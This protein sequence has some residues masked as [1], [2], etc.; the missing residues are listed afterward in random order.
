MLQVKLSCTKVVGL[1]VVSKPSWKRC[2]LRRDLKDCVNIV[3]ISS[4]KGNGDSDLP[5]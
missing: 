2:V 5:E 3:I 1:R 4:I